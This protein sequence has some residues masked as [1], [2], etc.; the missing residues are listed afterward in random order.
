MIRAV[1][2]NLDR[3]KGVT[4][5]LR[6]MAVKENVDVIAVQEPYIYRGKIK[7]FGVNVRVAFD[8][9]CERP[10]GGVIVMNRNIG[11]MKVMSV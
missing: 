9:E 10:W 3:S 4:S 5:E 2:C 8:E 1:E 6:Q 11:V 7:S